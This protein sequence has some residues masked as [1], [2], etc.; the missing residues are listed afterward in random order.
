MYLNSY[1]KVIVRKIDSDYNSKISVSVLQ[2]I[3][4]GI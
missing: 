3:L 2:L 4:L 1:E